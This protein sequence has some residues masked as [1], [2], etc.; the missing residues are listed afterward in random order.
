MLRDDQLLPLLVHDV[1]DCAPPQQTLVPRVLTEVSAALPRGLIA[2]LITDR[3]PEILSDVELAGRVPGARRRHL[4]RAILLMEDSRPL[5]GDLAEGHLEGEGA[6]PPKLD[7][8]ATLALPLLQDQ[9]LVGLLNENLGEPAL[10]FETGLVDERLDLV[11]EMLILIGHG[12][13]HLQPR[14]E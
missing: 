1:D 12:K 2:H 14:F 9:F 5:N 7:A 10:D 4:Q 8:S 13:G 11:G 3:V 6:C